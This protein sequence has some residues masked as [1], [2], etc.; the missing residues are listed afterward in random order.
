VTQQKSRYVLILWDRDTNAQITATFNDINSI[1]QV[2]PGLVRALKQYNEQ[3][4][5]K[6]VKAED[7][8][9][10]KVIAEMKWEQ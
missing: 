10:E 2:P 9:I 6:I 4:Q 5:R 3:H 7:V 1:D 8:D